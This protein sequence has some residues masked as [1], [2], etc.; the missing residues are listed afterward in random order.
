MLPSD[1][2]RAS[3][4]TH[5][6]IPW[7]DCEPSFSETLII[8]FDTRNSIAP[9]NVSSS[10]LPSDHHL[11]LFFTHSGIWLFDFF[12]IWFVVGS[13][14]IVDSVSSSLWF[15]VSILSTISKYT[16]LLLSTRSM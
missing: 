5:S 16:S 1:H 11:A 9:M 7:I 2:H 14:S 10:M 4:F 3:V 12:S 15:D 6:G 13:D 8:L